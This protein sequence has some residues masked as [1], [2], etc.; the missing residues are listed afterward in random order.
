MMVYKLTDGNAMAFSLSTF[1][2]LTTEVVLDELTRLALINE[3]EQSTRLVDCIPG[4]ESKFISNINPP[5]PYAHFC[6][7]SAFNGINLF[8]G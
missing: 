1:L 5:E 6:K 8:F 3:I 4:S 2:F 7:C